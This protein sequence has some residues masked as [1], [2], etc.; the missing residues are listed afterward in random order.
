MI[1]APRILL[2]DDNADDRALASLLLRQEFGELAIDEAADAIAFAEFLASG[3]FTV[4]VASHGLGWGDGCQVLEALRRRYAGCLL[5]LVCAPDENVMAHRVADLGLAGCL[6][7]NS[8]GFLTLSKAIRQ[9]LERAGDADN[10]AADEASCRRLVQNLPV[11]VF[12]LSEDGVLTGGNRA[13]A[14]LLGLAPEAR[15]AGQRI[16]DLFAGGPFAGRWSALVEQGEPVEAWDAPIRMHGGDARRVRLHIRPAVGATAN[17][18]G[19]YGCVQDLSPSRHADGELSHQAE[20]PA[21]SNEVLDQLAYVVSHDLQEP[22]QLMVRHARLLGDRYRSRLEREADRSLDHLLSNADRMQIMIDGIMDYLRVGS[23]QTS[24]TVNFGAVVDEVVARLAAPVEE[25]RARIRHN[26]LPVLTADRFQMVHLF[27]NLIGNAIKFRGAA[28]PRIVVAA[29]E[30]DADW[31]FGVKDNGIG[32]DPRHHQRIFEMF[33]R[34]HT[35]E[36]Y[37]GTG[38]GLAM[39][40]RIVERHGGRIWVNSTPG[41]GSTFCLTIPK[42]LLGPGQPARTGA[43][44]G[45]DES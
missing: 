33:H 18:A 6:K 44:Y 36:E 9:A 30:R 34:L 39:C 22:L 12:S 35:T 43:P 29:E 21:H 31:Q 40:R 32:I 14:T 19:F 17:V 3:G 26:G 16:Q 28:S 41:D 2:V 5:F 25:T 1:E 8:G 7:K 24:D 42:T 45:P 4:A 13:A 11:G 20:G 37:L 10:G 27:Q 23:G 15:V 38:I